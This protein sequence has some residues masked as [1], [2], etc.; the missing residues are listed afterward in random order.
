M[1]G[2][3]LLLEGDRHVFGRFCIFRKICE[4]LTPRSGDLT[5]SCAINY[6]TQ[7]NIHIY[8]CN[9]PIISDWFLPIYTTDVKIESIFCYRQVQWIT[10]IWILLTRNYN[11]KGGDLLPWHYCLGVTM[12][13]KECLALESKRHMNLY[14]CVTNWMWTHLQ[15]NINVHEF[16]RH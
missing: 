2:R 8:L 4:R 7:D 14:N 6:F 9:N 15:G 16:E 11:L 3:F 10:V 12:D 1:R 13:K 5:K